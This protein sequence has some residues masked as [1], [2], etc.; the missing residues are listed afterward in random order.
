[1]TGF[2]YA[3]ARATAERLLGRFGQAMTL[4]VPGAATGD[5]WNPTLGA[6]VSHACKGVVLDYSVHD[7]KNTL[8]LA[9]DRQVY[10]S[11]E[12]LTATPDPA[13]KLTIGGETLAIVEVKPLNPGGTTILYEIQVRR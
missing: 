8:I 1:M 10:L 6:P 12:G 2:D 9:G 7:R 4:V 3:K 11:T 5:P 13:H